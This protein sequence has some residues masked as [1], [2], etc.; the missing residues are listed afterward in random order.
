MHTSS[1]GSLLL[2]AAALAVAIFTQSPCRGQDAVGHKLLGTLGLQAGSPPPPGI[3]VVDRIGTYHSDELVDR[4]GNRLPVGLDLD[5]LFGNVGISGTYEWKQI[6]TYLTAAVGVPMA[7][8]SVTTSNPAASIDRFGLG[9]LYVQPL[10][11]GWSTPHLDALVGYAL[12]LPTGGHEP[13]GNDGI[14]RGYLSQEPSLGATAWFDG[15]RTWQ[16]TALASYDFNLKTR[17]VDITR[18]QTLQVQGGLGKK[19]FGMLDLGLAAYAL[20]QTTDDAG[21]ALPAAV[22]GA[23]DAAYGLGPEIDVTIPTIRTR[24]AM[25]YEH[26]VVVHS[27]PLGQTFLVTLTVNPWRLPSSAAP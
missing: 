16:L 5:A 7:R 13:G 18:G 26:D 3:Y 8:V 2:F 4:S 9:D 14:G 22:R 23:R 20:W 27:R 24:L 17:D 25:R 6:S 21:S 12:Y 11:L 15:D 19:L 1:P 10:Q